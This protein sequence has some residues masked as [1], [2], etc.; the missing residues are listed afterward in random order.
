MV[1][2]TKRQS[3]LLSLHDKL[4]SERQYAG[5]YASPLPLPY[6][7]ICRYINQFGAGGYEKQQLADILIA[8]DNY[9]LELAAA[10]QKQRTEN[11]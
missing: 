8:I 3:F 7:L 10:E 1:K 6:S 2:V 4:Q 11:G 5:Q 9:T